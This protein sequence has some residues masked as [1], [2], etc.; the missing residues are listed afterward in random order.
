MQYL[1]QFKF[2]ICVS[3]VG[4]EN[5]LMAADALKPKKARE[6]Y[7]TIKK[8]V[9]DTREITSSELLS[10]IK[11]GH[12]FCSV[13]KPK[14]KVYKMLNNGATVPVNCFNK[15]GQITLQGT[16]CE[17]FKQTPCIFVDI[18]KTSYK[19]FR[20][21]L[22]ALKYKPTVAYT[23]PS[24]CPENRRFRLVYVFDSPIT[25]T[26]TFQRYAEFI[27]TM[28][29][30]STGDEMKDTC[31]KKENQKMFGSYNAH[32]TYCSEYVYNFVDF[33]NLGYT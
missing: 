2:N 1:P 4:Y 10:Y 11:A 25:N 27:C 29:V 30:Y 31:W 16:V 15:A 6:K 23:T 33:E 13:F 18:D 19:N 21:Y 17:F 32:E 9:F 3:A 14:Q 20:D 26:E 5:K 24:D 7:T 22:A 12:T 28:V 8:T